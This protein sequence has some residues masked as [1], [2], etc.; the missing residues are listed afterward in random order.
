MWASRPVAREAAQRL[1]AYGPNELQSLSRES[2]WRTFVAQF[3][4]VLILILLSATL[5]PASSATRSRP[6]S[7]R[8]SCCLPC[9]WVLSGI[10]CRTRT[11]SVAEDGG[12]R[13]TGASRRTGGRCPARDLVPGDVVLLRAGDRVPADTRLTQAVNLAIDEAA[14]TG[15]S[16][17]VQKTIDA[18]DDPVCRWATDGT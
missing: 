15:E 13:R 7:S 17:P 6:S 3:Q 14:L 4:N 1:E 5:S 10:P 11:R 2:A 8:S 12:A 16:E 9:C 18:F